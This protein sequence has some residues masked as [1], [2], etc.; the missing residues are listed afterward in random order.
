MGR[1]EP[2]SCRGWGAWGQSDSGRLA[3][4]GGRSLRQTL[5]TAPHVT[6]P[7]TMAWD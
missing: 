2:E 5:A 1:C 3:G 4:S 7:H 6:T